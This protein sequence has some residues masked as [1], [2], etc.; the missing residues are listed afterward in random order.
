MKKFLLASLAMATALAITPAAMADSIGTIVFGGDAADI[1]FNASGVTATSG[2]G[3]QVDLATGV[4]SGL[5]GDTAKFYSWTSTAIDTEAFS[6]GSGASGTTFTIDSVSSYIYTGG[7]FPS[8][9][10]LGNGVVVD[11]GTS[12]DVS[13]QANGG[14]DGSVTFD[15]GIA[16]NTTPEPSSLVLLGTGLLG[17]AFF[18]FRKAKATGVVLSM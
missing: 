18:A 11:D 9:L 13:W 16:A 6:I 2:A 17:L 7:A 12:Y 5:S 14:A 10:A 8:L 4:F 15:Y 1:T 3:G